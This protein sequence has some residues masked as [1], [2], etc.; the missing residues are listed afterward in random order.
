VCSSDLRDVLIS[1]EPKKFFTEP[2][3][4]GFPAGLVRLAAVNAADLR[5]LLGEAWRCQ[6]APVPAKPRKK[7]S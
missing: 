6:A 7:R 1:G 5:A 4:N 2:H 3:Y